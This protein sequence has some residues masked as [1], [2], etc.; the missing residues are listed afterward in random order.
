MRKLFLLATAF[1]VFTSS[2]ASINTETPVLKADQLFFPV[3]KNGE[4]IS[5]AQLASISIADLQALTGKKMGFFQRVN[6]RMAQS[7]MRKSIA[8]D[9]TIK[10]KKVTKFFTTKGRAGETGFHLGGFALG[11]FVGLIGVLIAYLIKD[12]FKRNRVKWAWIGWGIFV[13]IYL[14]LLLAFFDFNSTY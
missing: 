6:F 9:G 14:V 2:F 3:G 4:K 13:V 8:S 1:F 5:Y 10:N 7:K 12:D 11:F